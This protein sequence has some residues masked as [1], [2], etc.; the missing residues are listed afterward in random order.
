MLCSHEEPGADA[1]AH[2]RGRRARPLHP[3]FRPRRVDDAVQHVSPL[4]GGRAPDPH[5]RRALRHRARRGRRAAPARRPRS[6]RPSST[7][8]RST[9]PRSCTTSPRAATRITPSPA[10]ASPAALCPRLGLTA[11][12]TETAAWLIEH[13]LVMSQIAFS[14]DIGDPKTIRDF[15]NIVQ[16]PERLKLLLVLTVAD[17]RAVGPGVWNGWKGQLLRGLYYET[18]PLVAGGHT[19]LASRERVAAAQAAFRAAVADWPAAGGRALHRPALSRLL[20]AHRH[21]QGG[22]ARQARAATPSAPARSLP[23]TSPPTPSPPSPSCRCSRPT[24]PACWRCL[25]A[26]APPPAPTSPAPTSPPRATA[27]RS[28]PSCWRASSS[29]TRTSCAAR[30]ASPRPS[31]RLLKGEI[32]LGA[33]MAKRRDRAAAGSTPSRWRPRC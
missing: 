7:G 23:A 3:R 5:H 18:E 19:Q 4:H 11:A 28:T 25:P 21:A 30:G 24:I 22:G 20:A 33:L 2:E 1:A 26:P 12:E 15:A 13:H 14:R 29:R 17:I 31:S 27:S 9:W 6:S 16:S 32:R 10:P 8:A